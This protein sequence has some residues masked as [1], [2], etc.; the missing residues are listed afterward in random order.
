MQKNMLMVLVIIIVNRETYF[1]N[2]GDCVFQCFQDMLLISRDGLAT[3]VA[4]VMKLASDKWLRL[5]ETTR[6]QVHYAFNI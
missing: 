5:S 2:Y 1:D 3:S 6:S 4:I